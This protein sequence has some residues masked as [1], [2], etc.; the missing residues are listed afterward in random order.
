[1][2][3]TLIGLAAVSALLVPAAS[4]AQQSNPAPNTS[5][6]SSAAASSQQPSVADAARKAKEQ[7]AAQ[8]QAAPA[9]PRVFDNDNIPTTGG[10]SAVGS[11][12]TGGSDDSSKNSDA[13]ASSGDSK[14]SAA[15][16]GKD[17]KGWRDLFKNLHHRL[18]Q[19]Q[20]ELDLDQRE[21]G[22]ADVQYYSDPVKGMQQGLTRS[23]IN[24]KTAK[25]DQVKK[26]IEADKQAI[27]DAEEQL[28]A[29]GGDP[30]WAR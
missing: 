11:V 12:H 22:V 26:R 25:I 20:E 21:L 18:D 23:D 30:G 13:S 5:S 15:L 28:R 17:E 2:R 29:A 4:R 7:K 16:S 9:T 8:G 27:S 1:M 14:G 6:Q 3:I 10:I 24:D 19:D